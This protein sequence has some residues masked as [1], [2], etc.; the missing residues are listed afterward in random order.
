MRVTDIHTY[1]ATTRG[2]LGP[3]KGNISIQSPMTAKPQRQ[4]VATGTFFQNII[5]PDMM[6]SSFEKNLT[7]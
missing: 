4:T 2:P 5:F 3:K 6:T 7:E 1:R